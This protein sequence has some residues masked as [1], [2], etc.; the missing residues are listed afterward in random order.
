[1]E[2]SFCNMESEINK[3]K[4]ENPG[5]SSFMVFQKCLQFTTNRKLR[6]DFNSFV[7]KSDYLPSEKEALIRWLKSKI[8]KFE[9]A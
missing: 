2:G 3:L 1:M 4:N 5:L 8:A 6:R 7:D 9:M